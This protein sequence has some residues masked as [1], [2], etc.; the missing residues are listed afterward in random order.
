MK[1]KPFSTSGII[2]VIG[3]CTGLVALMAG[4]PHAWSGHG[5]TQRG[6]QM[7]RAVIA[8]AAHAGLCPLIA[9]QVKGN[10]ASERIQARAAICVSEKVAQDPVSGRRVDL[11]LSSD[12]PIMFA[13][14][15]HRPLSEPRLTVPPI[16]G[17]NLCAQAYRPELRY[18]HRNPDHLVMFC[19][20]DRANAT[21]G[22]AATPIA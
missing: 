2:P 10:F 22:Q 8:R 9:A 17:L 15:D 3:F 14:A 19:R 21:G 6:F 7:K 1:V 11:G 5:S 12:L 18:P 20:R 13:V 16:Y 4:V